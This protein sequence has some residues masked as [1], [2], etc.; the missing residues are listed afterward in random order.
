MCYTTIMNKKQQLKKE[1]QQ[2]EEEKANIVAKKR[3][4]IQNKAHSEFMR[5][6]KETEN[7]LD[8]H[9]D[10]K[11]RFFAPTEEQKQR[12]EEDIPL[13]L[14]HF[15]EHGSISKACEQTKSLN[16][17]A[18]YYLR[19]TEPNFKEDYEVAQQIFA[20]RLQDEAKDR[21]INGTDTPTIFKGEH[22][23]TVKMPDNR[24]LE[25]VLR[26]EVP[27]KYDRKSLD[28]IPDAKKPQLNL[29]IIN[30][31]TPDG[32]PAHL[33][34]VRNVTDDGI[35]TKDQVIDVTAQEKEN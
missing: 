22:I 18:I 19:Q 17:A 21:A 24:L 11:S 27:E 1:I 10:L 35:I 6:A 34:N 28:R 29:N 4:D 23:D 14:T 16:L 13:F 7:L 30:F 25:T 8:V 20:T 5:V 31:N 3:K 33:G 15:S 26:S 2:L 32:P 9:R 12:F